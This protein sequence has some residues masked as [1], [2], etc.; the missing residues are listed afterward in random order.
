M[1]SVRREPIERFGTSPAVITEQ[2]VRVDKSCEKARA[3]AWI[4]RIRLFLV[5]QAQQAEFFLVRREDLDGE[6]F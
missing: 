4:F 1:W 2:V 3:L 6:P 5:P